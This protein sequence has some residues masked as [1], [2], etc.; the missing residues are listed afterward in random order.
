MV[1]DTLLRKLPH[2]GD[3]VFRMMG[4]MDPQTEAER[5]RDLLKRQL[6]TANNLPVF[7]LVLLGMGK[8]GHT[9]SIFPDQMELLHTDNL[10][11]VG[12][13]P[14]SGQRR[15]TLTGKVINNADH[16]IFL[17]TGAD[18]AKTVVEILGIGPQ[19]ETFPAFHI[20]PAHGN[21]SWFLD[22]SAARL[23]QK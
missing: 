8:D 5:Y 17:V 4:E 10:C 12:V 23:L 21:L 16:V 7:D 14:E 15:L 3:Y 22:D 1:N 20:K 13:H 18:K 19:A 11:D 2:S 9:A 6:P